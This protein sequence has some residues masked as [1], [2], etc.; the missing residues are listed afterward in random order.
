MIQAQQAVLRLDSPSYN[1]LQWI[2][3]K[4]KMNTFCNGGGLIGEQTTATYI[5][6]QRI[7]AL[8]YT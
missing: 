8:L 4:E 7:D 1:L 6:K 5:Q 2:K 3:I